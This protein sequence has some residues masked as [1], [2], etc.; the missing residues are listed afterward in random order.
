LDKQCK[1]VDVGT[2]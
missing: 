2:I 1:N